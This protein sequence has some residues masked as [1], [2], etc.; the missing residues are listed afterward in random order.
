MSHIKVANTHDLKALNKAA[1]EYGFNRHVPDAFLADLDPEGYHI[2]S[3]R[4][5]DH[6]AYDRSL[7]IHHRAEVWCKMLGSNDPDH[8]YIDIRAEDWDN[9]ADAQSEPEMA[10]S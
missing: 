10:D 5:F 7:P 6:Q 2:L 4:L 9:L 8:I 1:A 3:L